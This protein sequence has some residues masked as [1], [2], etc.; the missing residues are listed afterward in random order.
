MKTNNTPILQLLSLKHTCL[1]LISLAWS[2]QTYADKVSGASTIIDKGSYPSVAGERVVSFSLMNTDTGQP[3]GTMNNGAILNLATLPT[4]NLNIRANTSP[5]RVGSVIFDLSGAETIRQVE[6][7]LPY[8]LFGGTDSNYNPWTPAI[9]SYTLKAT[10]YSGSKGSG[11][12]DSALTVNFKVINSP[13]P[14]E[15]TG[16]LKKWHKITLTFTGPS[17]GETAALNPFLNYRLNVTF[18]K[19]NR[20]L[21][22]PGYFAAD[23]NATETGATSGNKWRVHFTPDEEGTWSYKASFR[24]GSD[25]AVSSSAT[26]GSPVSFDGITGDIN[27]GP[28]DKTGADLRAQG[29]LQYVGGHYL[30]FAQTGA[31]F[32]KGGANSPENFLAYQDFDGTYSAGSTNTIKTYTPHLNDWKSDDPTWKGGKGKGIIG[33]LN[34]LASKG[35]NA[36]YFLTMNVDGDGKDVWPW[37]SYTE[38]TR[39]DV[40]KLDQWE[41]VFTQMDKL[42]LMMHVVT[43]EIE[44]DQLLDDGA[45]G[46]QRKL[47]YRELI[48]RFGHHLAI[49]WNLGEENSN[50]DA[51]RKEF[52]D[53][54]KSLDPYKS[55]INVHTYPTQL[56]EVYTPLLGYPTLNGASLQ[57]SRISNVHKET[58]KW[59]NQSAASGQKWVV[60]LDEIGPPSTGVVPDDNDPAH[61]QVRKSALWGNLMAGGGGVEWYFGYS[62]PNNDLAAQDWRSRDHMW[63]LTR[64][65]L[66]F[67]QQYLPFNQMKSMDSLTSATTDY[68]FA[69][70]EETY[71]I[72]LPGG[73]TTSLNLGDSS[74]L[75]QVKWYNPRTGG[76]LQDGS[77]QQIIGPGYRSIGNPPADVEADWVCLITKAGIDTGPVSSVIP[78]ATVTGDAKPLVSVYPNPVKDDI[79]VQVNL[80]AAMPL[81]ISLIDIQG[82][83]VYSITYSPEKYFSKAFSLRTIRAG[84]YLLKVKYGDNYTTQRIIKE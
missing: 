64:Y 59:V 70:P 11:T 79:T 40:S 17:T 22:V 80:P 57:I 55:F 49:D 56:S 51:Q 24:S 50:T 26:A 74:N 18:T 38:R 78:Q 19:G 5:T 31:Y 63:D 62:Y 75:Y 46:V 71:A 42:G 41:V 58:L 6:N 15:V 20:Q 27:V 48:A 39:F 23:G 81:E 45:L 65:A 44:N 54:I 76:T 30:Q 1:L 32:L 82:R 28:T 43:Q 72:Y 67:F 52:A 34:Y 66:A 3:I 37:T 14:A 8:A 21:V 61:D 9:G 4:R 60:S 35:M 16:E 53:Y 68:C 2:L 73:D 69:L 29:R 10:P 36:V 12:A 47:Y 83:P 33:A 13:S 25:I 84:L 77:V 7:I